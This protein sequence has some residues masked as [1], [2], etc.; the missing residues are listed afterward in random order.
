MKAASCKVLW[1][2]I[3]GSVSSQSSSPS[4]GPAVEEGG[5]GLA[6]LRQLNFEHNRYIQNSIRNY[7]GIIGRVSG[8]I[9]TATHF[10]NIDIDD[11]CV[12]LRWCCGKSFSLKLKV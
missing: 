9:C 12:A 11:C 2:E 7:A 3:S 5:L 4:L 1:P 8:I 6:Q 10:N